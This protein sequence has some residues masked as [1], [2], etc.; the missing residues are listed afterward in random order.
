M[1]G[2]MICHMVGDIG[3]NDTGMSNKWQMIIRDKKMWFIR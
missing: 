3:R 1:G 2:R